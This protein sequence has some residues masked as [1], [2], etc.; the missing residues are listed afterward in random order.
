MDASGDA[1]DEL[2][3]SVIFED[4][5]KSVGAFEYDSSAVAA[6]EEAV[7]RFTI[8]LLCDAK[9]YSSHAEKPAI[10][11]ADARVA[12]ETSDSNLHK[13]EDR[14]IFLRDVAKEINRKS[15]L[16]LLDTST[17]K[18]K[19]AHTPADVAKHHRSNSKLLSRTCTLEYGR[20]IIDSVRPNPFLSSPL[21]IICIVAIFYARDII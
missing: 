7:A 6:L 21:S 5:L 17:V 16:E 11:D 8:D 4:L 9:D 3:S 20:D 13:V 14:R 1:N 12:I 10:D 18:N 15:L 19:Y 2:D